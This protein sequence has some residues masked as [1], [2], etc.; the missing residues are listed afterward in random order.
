MGAFLIG[1]VWFFSLLFGAWTALAVAQIAIGRALF[2]LFLPKR[3]PWSDGEARLL[4]LGWL[5][6]GLSGLVY[7]LIGG[8]SLA[9]H[10][11]PP[12]W[13]VWLW[14]L[15]FIGSLA[16]QLLLASRHNKSWPFSRGDKQR[17]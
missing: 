13:V 5:V 9:A 1:T 14:S 7:V 2:L 10:Q 3:V 8:L 11:T 15:I 12:F 16:F 6:S 4:G 17:G